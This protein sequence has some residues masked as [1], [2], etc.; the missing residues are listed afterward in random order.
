M[1][2]ILVDSLHAPHQL[3]FYESLIP[4]TNLFPQE[5][6]RYEQIHKGFIGEKKL[7]KY[8]LSDDYR[9]IIPLYNNLFEV[10]E[11]EFQVDCILLTSDTIFLLE[12]KNYTGDYYNE[13]GQ[14]AIL[15]T[16][17]EIF[18]PVS[19]LDRTELLF[20]R[21]LNE[22]QIKMKIRS[23]VIFINFN[24]MLY[25]ASTRQPI[26]FPSQIKRFLQKTNVNAPA[27]RKDIYQLAKKLIAR[28]K[29]RSFYERLPNYNMSQL[30]QGVF[31]WYC[32]AKLNRESRSSFACL[33]C[34]HKY[35]IEEV[36]IYAIAQFHLLFPHKEITNKQITEWCGRVL[37][38]DYIGK[39][40]NKN[41]N[42]IEKGSQTHY[43]YKNKDEHLSLLANV[44]SKRYDA[45]KSKFI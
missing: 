38:R 37:S 18:N 32:F 23:F 25:G 3:L 40:L 14:I 34:D 42:V 24:F 21:L 45:F 29:T 20:K 39:I 28:R 44:C 12:V 11:T 43:R 31:C 4:R 35:E 5:K 36:I 30:K 17:I 9:K 2:M 15:Q 8:I 6:Q 1:P 26:I 41:F 19:Q 7:E 16:G 33:R 13:N 10:S 27:L 22:K